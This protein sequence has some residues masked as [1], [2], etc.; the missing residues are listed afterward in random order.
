MA[1]ANSNTNARPEIMSP[2]PAF[3]LEIN[4]L[5]ESP[6]NISMDL[7]QILDTCECF[8]DALI[9]NGS[10]IERMALCG[11]LYAGLEVLKVVLEAPL[12]THL[13]ER[14]TVDGSQNG[15]YI[16]P[17]S[18]DSETLRVYCSAL[19]LLLLNKQHSAEQM[20]H[21]TGLLFEMLNVLGEDLRAPRFIRTD[22]GLAMIGGEK[23]P[24]SH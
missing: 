2:S 9:E 16:S 1:I 12:P 3:D 20:E 14:L 8:I 18:S 7:F 11:R 23:V 4:M 13:I 10:T 24:L 21:I 17:L 22:S 19:T 5:L 6:L 15:G